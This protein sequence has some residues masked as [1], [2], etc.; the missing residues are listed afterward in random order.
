MSLYFLA[1]TEDTGL[2]DIVEIT[3]D[4]VRLLFV[5]VSLL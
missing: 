4:V 2:G 1:F 5:I 3:L